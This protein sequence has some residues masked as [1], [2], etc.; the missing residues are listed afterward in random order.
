MVKLKGCRQSPTKR[1][2]RILS[3]GAH[4]HPSLMSPEHVLLFFR[5]DDFDAASHEARILNHAA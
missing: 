2:G 5:V 4:E 1:G 3:L